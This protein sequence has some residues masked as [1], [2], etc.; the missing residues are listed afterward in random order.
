MRKDKRKK[1]YKD[2]FIESQS[3]AHIFSCLHRIRQACVTAGILCCVLR[4]RNSARRTKSPRA[5]TPA[6]WATTFCG[7]VISP[8]VSKKLLGLPTMTVTTHVLENDAII[9][10]SQSPGQVCNANTFRVCSQ[11]RKKC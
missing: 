4:R 3:R 11:L 1:V 2:I 5:I 9:F 6:S 10:F 7:H 8:G